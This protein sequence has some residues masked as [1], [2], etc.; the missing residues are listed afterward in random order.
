MIAELKNFNKL[1]LKSGRK[2]DLENCIRIYTF[3]AR[4]NKRFFIWD[5]TPSEILK[6]SKSDSFLSDFFILY[7]SSF[8]DD[9]AKLQKNNEP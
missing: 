6:Y 7:R 9:N 4:N 3:V 8:S 1:V 2:K 5:P